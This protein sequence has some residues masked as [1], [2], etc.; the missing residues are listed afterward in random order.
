MPRTRDERLAALGL[1]SLADLLAP[2][3]LVIA[4]DHLVLDGQ[5]IRVLAVGELPPVVAAGWL[6]GV[7]A[8]KLAVD[9]SLHLRPLHAGAAASALKLKSWR[10]GG[11]LS[12]DAANGRPVDNNLSTA[13]EQIE[14]LRRGLARRETALFSVGLYLQV[15]ASSRAELDELT[16]HVAG[17]LGAQAGSALVPRLQQEQGFRA[18]LPE[19]RD[20]L[21]VLHTLDTG[22]LSTM[23]PFVPATPR[24]PHGILFGVDEQVHDLVELDVFD[25][26]VCQ[27]ANIGIFAPSGGGKT[28]FTKLLARRYL[29]MTDNTD[30]IVIDRK[31]EY[32]GLCDALNGQ[33][34]RVAASS[35]HRINPLDLPP[36]DPDAEGS[37]LLDH[38]QQVLGLLD[39]LLAEPGQRLSLPERAVLDRAIKEAYETAGITDNPATHVKPPPTMATLQAVLDAEADLSPGNP[40]NTAGTLAERLAVFTSGSLAGGLLGGLT[41]VSLGSRL[42]V[43]GIEELPEDLWSF[44]MYLIA[45]CVWQQVRLRPNRQRLL[46]VD[47][48]WLLLQHRDGGRFLESIV[49]LARSY[50]LGLVFITQDVKNVLQDPRGSVIAENVFTTLLLRQSSKSPQ[51]TSQTQQRVAEQ[52]ALSSEEQRMLGSAQ[53]GHGLLLV[54]PWRIHLLVIASNAEQRIAMTA[55]RERQALAAA[56]AEGA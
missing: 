21:Q 46:V 8:E 26:R 30:V 39:V 25:H 16:Q 47:E 48:A 45:G 29:L 34:L 17:L 56:A 2:S 41:N 51:Q 24:M 13:F 50:G 35:P 9:L 44:A 49:R 42:V 33:F 27:N 55:P 43:F 23:F 54:G 7:L 3:S 32:R 14:R 18:S 5:Y 37:V 22:T 12:D 19:A 53:P 38:I 6:S 15:H 4:D 52:F 40:G 36:P 20:P 11:A 31:H 28:F 10:L 1:R